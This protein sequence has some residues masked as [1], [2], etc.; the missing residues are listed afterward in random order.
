MSVFFC[1]YFW[2]LAVFGI[3]GLV[4]DTTLNIIL[5]LYWKEEILNLQLPASIYDYF[6]SGTD[7]RSILNSY[8]Q[9]LQKKINVP[10]TLNR[11]LLQT[12]G[13]KRCLTPKCLS[14]S[15]PNISAEAG[16]L[17]WHSFCANKYSGLRPLGKSQSRLLWKMKYPQRSVP[18]VTSCYI[19]R[20]LNAVFC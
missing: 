13:H 11:T 2:R 6:E 16:T 12:T 3:N 5:S 8:T 15:S 14:F 18:S 19:L 4:A 20:F 7:A 10:G 9:W 17:K 1:T